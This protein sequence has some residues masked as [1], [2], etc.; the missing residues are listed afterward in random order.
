MNQI[1]QLPVPER[2]LP[3]QRHAAIRAM[4]VAE[5][6]RRPAPRPRRVVTRTRVLVAGLATAVLMVAAQLWP[7]PYPYE[8]T[9][10]WTA[11]PRRVDQA[12][13]DLVAQTCARSAASFPGQP[14]VDTW[15]PAVVDVRGDVAMAVVTSGDKHLYCD[16]YGVGKLEPSREPLRYLASSGSGSVHEPLPDGQQLSLSG[17]GEF[18][19]GSYEYAAGRVIGQ[20]GPEVTRVVVELED[21]DEV[22]ATVGDGWYVA[23][24]PGDV[25]RILLFQWADVPQPVTVRAYGAEGDLLAELPVPPR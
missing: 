12:T 15:R 17:H 11:E 16:F 23:W 14:A 7:Q 6:A 9:A 19:S 22:V 20:V 21:G 10:G 2:D 18:G 24:W 4:L 3:A 1:G 8:L 25:R 13:V 5:A